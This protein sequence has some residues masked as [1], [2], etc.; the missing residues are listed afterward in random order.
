MSHPAVRPGALIAAVAVLVVAP[1]LVV[2]QPT[3]VTGPRASPHA[4]VT[5]TIGVTEVVVDYHRPAVNGR[6]VWGGLVP[7]DEVWRAG[8]NENTTVSFSTDALVEGQPVAA[9]TYGLHMVPGREVWTVIFSRQAQA[10]GSFSYD[11]AEDA[12]RVAVRPRSS[13]QRE[14]LEYRFDEVGD[15][16]AV[17]VLDWAGLAVP[18][19]LAV[20][21]PATLEQD[22]ATQ[23]RGLPRFSW[24]GWNQ[25][26]TLLLDGG[27]DPARAM[28]WVDRSIAMN[29]NFTNLS[30]RSRVL[31]LQGDA[32]A[33]AALLA[34]A[35]ENATEAELNTYG[36]QLMLGQN[37]LDEALD[38]FAENVRRHPDSWNVYDSLGE[39]Q[40]AKGLVAE[41]I[42]NYEKARSL[43]TDP[44]QLDRIDGVLKGLRERD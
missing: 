32:T 10:W 7:W 3:P 30:T 19:R 6:Q 11:E 43:A 17:L 25:A 21:L 4:A 41:A 16:T 44:V 5:Q 14:R 28:E 20:D 29:R 12:L 13:A 33:A 37:E 8:A 24:Q 42:A 9:G 23:L 26:A 15:R 35:K 1:S 38:V 27:G 34:E 22:L 36:Y 2:A 31:A 39:A 18:V 40:A